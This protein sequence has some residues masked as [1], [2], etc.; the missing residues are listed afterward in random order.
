MKIILTFL[1]LTALLL[2]G[3]PAAAGELDNLL[4]LL[5]IGSW[6]EDSPSGY[7]VA[8]FAADG[9]YR[10]VMY[11]G[12]DRQEQLM[13]LN[14]TWWITDGELHNILSAAE[15]EGAPLGEDFVDDVVLINHQQVVLRDS[16]G[17]RYS[18]IRLSSTAKD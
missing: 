3:L 9:N 7:A 8:S 1:L 11:S 2:P 18:R 10:A 13:E 6:A 16:D 14:G 15:P 12:R 5:M 17:K 4:R